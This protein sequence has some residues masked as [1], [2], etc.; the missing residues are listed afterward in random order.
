MD[1]RGIL[2]FTAFEQTGTATHVEVTLQLFLWILTVTGQTLGLEERQ[3]FP[4]KEQ[5]SLHFLCN[6]GCL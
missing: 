3:H 1:E 5:I 6:H 4:R 2:A